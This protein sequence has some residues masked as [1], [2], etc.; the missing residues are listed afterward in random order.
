M[1]RHCDVPLPTAPA[2]HTRF[3]HK[4]E[5]TWPFRTITPV[6]GGGSEPGQHD[7]L[8]PVRGTAIRGHLR[9]WWRTI[10]G[11]AFSNPAEMRA[12]EAL[13]WGSASV[14]SQVEL[15]V[16]VT[17]PGTVED[18]VDYKAN[19]K[20]TLAPHPRDGYP[21][22]A[23]F[24]FLKTQTSPP[25]KAC[26]GQKFSITLR[27]P[28]ALER[29]LTA[30]VWAWANFGGIGARTRRGCGALFCSKLAPPE[31]AKL[32][33][34]LITAL[35][36]QHGYQSPTLS[37]DWPV[38]F[39]LPLWH[40]QDQAPT[41]AWLHVLETMKRFRQ[42][43]GIG[44]NHGSGSRPGRS[45]YP[46]ADSIRAILPGC[47]APAH[48]K[49]T[50][51]EPATPPLLPRSLF[52][53]PMIVQMK[54][55]PD[56]QTEVQILPATCGR[57]GRPVPLDRMASPLVLRPMAF[58]DGTHARGMILLLKSPKP[59]GLTVR[60]ASIKSEQFYDSSSM[61]GNRTRSYPNS[62][63]ARYSKSATDAVTAFLEFAKSERGYKSA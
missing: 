31:S 57:D 22:Y 41:T 37:V 7:A 17:N 44:R 1:P 58:G 27:A 33:H 53:L 48:A 10:R 9:F 61:E 39:A 52:G 29:E 32:K 56:F 13:I 54:G 15:T 40:N 55:D 28:A 42:E 19:A 12:A 4:E 34:W 35:M 51:I 6:F 36:Q 45:F 24:P 8:M 59:A 16:S 30:A 62:P 23:L 26:R 21:A 38:F 20:G 46:E 11:T 5:W 50:T 63:I 18:W 60:H 2:V 47:A 25:K 49:P 3:P 14:P 43:P